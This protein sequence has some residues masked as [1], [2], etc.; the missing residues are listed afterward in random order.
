[1][2]DDYINKKVTIRF[3]G[4][5]KIQRVLK[6]DE[7][8][9]YIKYQGQRVSIKPNTNALGEPIRGYYVGNYPK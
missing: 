7:S 6:Q 9:L 3:P 2:P 1:M 8:G 5:C 4:Y